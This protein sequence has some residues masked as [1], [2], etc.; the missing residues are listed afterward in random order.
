LIGSGSHR[1]RAG[2]KALRRE[3]LIGINDRRGFLL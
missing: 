3:S 2:A 1:P